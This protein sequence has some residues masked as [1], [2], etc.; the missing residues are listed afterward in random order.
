MQE[1]ARVI[2]SSRG[3]TATRRILI[4]AAAALVPLLAGC[5]AGTNAP[6]LHWHQPT[7]GT[8]KTLGA[9]TISNAF[10]LGA[11]VGKVL[12]SGQNAGLFLGL[13]NTGTGSDRLLAVHAPGVAGKVQV[14]AGGVNV[15]S[16]GQVLLTGPQP[17]I[18]LT[19]L[20]HPLT[21]GSVVT[22]YLRFAKC[23]HDQAPGPGDAGQLV[24][25]DA[26]ARAGPEQPVAKP[27]HLRQEAPRLGVPVR[28]ADAVAVEF[29]S[30]RPRPA[31]GPA[32]PGPARRARL[33]CQ[34]R[35]C[36]PARA[37]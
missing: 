18:V 37:R 9:I 29:L 35:T 1:E 7:D 36:S 3:G 12:H 28:L 4:A 11:P 15:A 20:I 13:T 21:G 33:S 34:A 8:H 30:A 2:R 24:L 25:H 16:N 31:A 32:E 19:N 26:L 6:T 23:G 27:V 22:L 10:V 17:Q 14:P 5:E